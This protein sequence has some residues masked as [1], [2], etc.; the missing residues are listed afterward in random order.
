MVRR[1]GSEKLIIATHNSGKLKE[2]SALLAPYCVAC[3][4]AGELGLAE[5]AET[6]TTFVEN[7][8]H[9]GACG[10]RCGTASGAGRR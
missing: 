7:A 10:G 1:L 5:P 2:I 3:V 6:G 9:Q 8:L 4:S